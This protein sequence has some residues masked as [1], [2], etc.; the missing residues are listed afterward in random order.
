MKKTLGA[1]LGACLIALPLAL[2]ANPAAEQTGS[3]TVTPVEVAKVKQVKTGTHSKAKAKA[4]VKTRKHVTTKAKAK[5]KVKSKKKAK[6][7][8]RKVGAPK[9][10]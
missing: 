3:Q 8:A 9:T 7:K 1:L 6:S 5:K 2:S 4:R 10:Q